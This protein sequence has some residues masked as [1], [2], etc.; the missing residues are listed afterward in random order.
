MWISHSQSSRAYAAW[1]GCKITLITATLK[2]QTP[3]TP[4]LCKRLKY[5][6]VLFPDTLFL[7]ALHFAWNTWVQPGTFFGGGGNKMKGILIV[8]NLKSPTFKKNARRK[9]GADSFQP[10]LF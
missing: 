10:P 4:F 8:A 6:F 1:L 9:D 5:L 2:C 7:F 3:S